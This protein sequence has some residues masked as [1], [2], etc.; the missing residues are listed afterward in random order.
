MYIM[1][2]EKWKEIKRTYYY[3]SDK[4]NSIYEISNKGRFRKNNIIQ[5]DLREVNGYYITTLGLLHRLVAKA[6][7]ENKDNKPCVDHID[8]D[9]HNNNICNLRWVTHKEN[10]NNPITLSRL[11]E[12]CK[13]YYET[14]DSPFK[15]KHHKE[16]T[17]VI[18]SNKKKG[19]PRTTPIWN[20]GI[21]PSKESIEKQQ[22]SRKKTCE[23]R[24][25]Y[26]SEEGKKRQSELMKGNQIAT[27]RIHINNGI[28]SKMIYPNELNY[29]K[30]IGYVEGRITYH[31]RRRIAN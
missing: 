8:G 3:N 13:K 7:I 2:Q 16:E 22:S 26:V 20:K 31:R 9:K 1:S 17:K 23:E 19:I 21:S 5:E 14:H 11:K 18:I 10:N 12:S 30:S 15:G 27:N 29:Y 24:G 28:E 6:F 4:I 25:Y